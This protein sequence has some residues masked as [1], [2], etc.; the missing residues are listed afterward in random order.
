MAW[1]GSASVDNTS[2]SMNQN[3]TAS[4][5]QTPIVSP[6]F[7]TAYG[8]MSGSVNAQGQTPAQVAAMNFGMTQMNPNTNP[9][10]GATATANTGLDNVNQTLG[11]INMG[12]LGQVVN[13]TA[14]PLQSAAAPTIN[15]ATAASAVAPY[16]SL[17]GS[18]VT[19]PALAAMDYGT[20]KAFSALDARTAGAGGFANSRSGLGYSD[21]GTQTALQRAQ[22]DAQL[23]TQGLTTGLGF[24]QG[25]VTRQQQADTQN[26]ANTLQNNQFNVNAGYE[27]TTQH[28]AA[29]KQMTD[30]LAQ[31]AGLSQQEL[32]N[33][34]GANG[35]NVD[36]ANAMFQAGTI[37]QQQLQA[38]VAAAQNYNGSAATGTQNTNGTSNST[39]VSVKANIGLP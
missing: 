19:D 7:N 21:L 36:A 10:N 13:N 29:I 38:I 1:G 2:K 33:V 8:N 17:W 35:I 25:D 22:L 26:A 15:S 4:S 23:N 9:V 27:G 24:A 34:I 11:Y 3:T 5:S 14:T 28:L 20:N 30:V 31:Q 32:N 18:A 6:Q 37:T 16:S 12:P 39:D